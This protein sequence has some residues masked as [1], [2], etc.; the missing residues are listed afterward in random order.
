MTT[1]NR[2][3]TVHLLEEAVK[4]LQALLSARS[5]EEQPPVGLAAV[6]GYSQLYSMLL[7][8]RTAIMAFASGNLN[9]QITKKGYLPGA[10]KALQAALHHLTWQ[11][12]MIASGDF[13]QRVD[14]MGDFSDSFNSMVRQLDDTMKQLRE[15]TEELDRSNSQMAELNRNI[16]D[17]IHYAK[18]IQS[19]LLPA[20]SELT[21]N[22]AF[23]MPVYLPRD[24]VGGDF[25]FFNRSDEGF[26]LAVIDCTGHGVPGALM[27]MTV[28]AV[29]GNIIA[30]HIATDPALILRQLNIEI[31]MM[32]N[33]AAGD[34]RID[35]GLDIGL[36]IYSNS[37][38]QLSF[39]G[40]KIDLL[41]ASPS[42]SHIS[43]LRGDRKSL[44]YRRSSVDYHFVRHDIALQN[45]Q[46]FCMSSDGLLDQPGGEKGLPFGSKRYH[47]LISELAAASDEDR[48]TLF[49]A[50]L[51]AWKGEYP[52]RD[53]IALCAFVPHTAA[54][55]AVL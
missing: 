14:F 11:T 51:Y 22:L 45:D 3:N 19:S 55:E 17:S 18:M 13:S 2:E 29:L 8:V 12:K 27:T 54:R 35:N 34:E 41:I 21:A 9:N 33:R 32:L 43:V 26:V 16:M 44:G 28:N 52:Q 48:S 10:I 40:A 6:D 5:V 47:E 20:E 36:C 23:A 46:F 39:A 4:N 24:V 15:R 53:D 31:K 37:A 50:R 7:E 49:H 25:L 1:L 38:R 30:R 42:G